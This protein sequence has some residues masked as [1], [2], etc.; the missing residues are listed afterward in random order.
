MIVTAN[1]APVDDAYPFF[2]GREWA[3]GD[4][5]LRAIELLS[6]EGEGG[7]SVDGLTAL[8]L[9]TVL[10][11]ARRMIPLLAADTAA[12]DDGTIVRDRIGNWD[13]HCDLASQGCAA[14]LTFELHLLRRI[15]DDELGPLAA[16][17][18]GSPFSWQLLERLLAEPAAPWWDDTTTPD[19]ET[20]D[21]IVRAALDE[22]GADLRATLGGDPARWTWERLHTVR[23]A[24]P[25]FGESGIGPLEFYLD[26]GPVPVDGAAGALLNTYYR[27]DRAYPDP[28]EP[29][30]PG[31]GLGEIFSVTNLPSYRLAIDMSDL[32]GARIITTTGQGGNPYG[33]H[34]GDLVDEWAAGETIPL[35]F[36]PGAVDA[37][38]VERL[39]LRP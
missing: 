7:E 13:A 32:D 26:A 23:F 29:D 11:R 8:Q 15:L 34:Y 25:T 36:S 6:G 28:D 21:E 17:Y 10:P 38:T 14:Y 16:D 22:S 12:T 30:E 3:R 19:V 9:D 37:A 33:P 1:N 27:L 35:P 24:E 5:A 39:T 31:L 18:V 20:R 2:L 4:R